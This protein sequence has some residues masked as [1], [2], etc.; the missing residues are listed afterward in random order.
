MTSPTSSGVR[1]A[2]WL[3]MVFLL[4]VI[5][6]CSSLTTV[7]QPPP[8]PAPTPQQQQTLNTGP[9]VSLA[10]HIAKL[11]SR[12]HS[13][14]EILQKEM[15]HHLMRWV[16]YL[17]WLLAL[18]L[19]PASAVREWRENAG[20]GRNLLW[21][22][23]RLAVCLLL[24]GAAIPIIDALYVV[25]K[26]IAGDSRDTDARSVLHDFYLDLQEAFNL[27]YKKLIDGNFKVKGIDVPEFAVQ[28]IDGSE[29]HVGVISDQGVTIRNPISS[30]N[31]SS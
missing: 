2:R 13:L 18:F 19:I 26:D 17:A 9:S 29:P 4:A 31:D 16:E 10:E 11:A 5:F 27:S 6:C 24:F 7:T 23:G 15:L 3:R 1:S 12:A 25:G 8:D 28:P 30:L 21:W 14:V 22:F 20:K